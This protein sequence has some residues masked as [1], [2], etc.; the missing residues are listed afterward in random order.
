MLKRPL[1]V[2]ESDQ[3]TASFA[4]YVDTAVWFS[5]TDTVW[6][7][8][9]TGLSSS[10]SVTVAVT[11]KSPVLLELSVAITVISYTLSELL[12]AGCS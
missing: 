6:L 5:W 1:S 3:V 9:I 10:K 8:V 12:S 7:P 2:P 4:L 11:A